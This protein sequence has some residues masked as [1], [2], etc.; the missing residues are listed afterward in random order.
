MSEIDNLQQENNILDTI[1]QEL[2]TLNN[3]DKAL[4]QEEQKEFLK[5][6]DLLKY[7]D[8]NKLYLDNGNYNHGEYE[9]QNSINLNSHLEKCD[10]KWSYIEYNWQKIYRRSK[11]YEKKGKSWLFYY[12]KDNWLYV[13]YFK[14]WMAEWYWKLIG[15]SP[16]NMHS[17]V[18]YNW[19][20]RRVQLPIVYEWIWEE[21]A[22]CSWEQYNLDGNDKI[23]SRRLLGNNNIR[24]R[25]RLISI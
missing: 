8:L 20:R 4:E 16:D 3:T 10:E 9:K 23:Y 19:T 15:L 13:W 14:N 7:L 21:N 2:V 5:W 24:C 18:F 6:F 11:K 1:P 25:Y 12:P 22:L 17:G